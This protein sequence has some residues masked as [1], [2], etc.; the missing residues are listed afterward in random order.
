VIPSQPGQTVQ[1][2]LSQKKSSG[3]AQGVGPEFKSQYHNKKIKINKL[4]LGLLSR[5]AKKN[6]HA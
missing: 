6:F 5:G 2:T 1:E 4:T 3:I